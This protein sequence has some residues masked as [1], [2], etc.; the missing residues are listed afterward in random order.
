MF[1]AGFSSRLEVSPGTHPVQEAGV[2]LSAGGEEG[3][4]GTED[5][6]KSPQGSLQTLSR[7]H[8]PTCPQPHGAAS[9]ASHPHLQSRV[10]RGT[11]AGSQG[12]SQGPPESQWP[13]CTRGA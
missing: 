5:E 10:S 9:L 1:P 13:P 2:L 8:P 3:V 7:R 12:F 4:G 11:E 6:L